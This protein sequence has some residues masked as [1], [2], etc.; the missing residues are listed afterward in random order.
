MKYIPIDEVSIAHHWLL[1]HGRY[2]C[3]SLRPK[4]E[5]CQF[6]DFCPKILENSKL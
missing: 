3:Q 6:D 1:L 5:D 4:C 2:V